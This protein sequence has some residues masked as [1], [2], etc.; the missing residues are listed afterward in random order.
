V[1]LS[2]KSGPATISGNTVTV[3]GIGTVMLAADQ[4]GTT[5]YL[6]AKEVTTTFTVGK[7]AQTIAPFGTLSPLTVGV[8]P[9]TIT[10][11]TASS[12]L[13]VAVT[14]KS[15]PAKLSGDLV[16]I[17]GAGTVVLSASQAG[18]TLFN[19]A[20][21]VTATFAV[22]KTAQTISAF[23]SISNQAYGA[24]AFAIT[25]PT[26]SSGLAVTVTVLS[27]PAKISRG[28]V[29]LSGA[30]TVVLAANQA[31]NTTIAAAPEVT[32]SFTVSQK[33][34]T[35]AAFATVPAKTYGVSAF[36]IAPPKATSGLAVTLS[37]QSGPATMISGRVM[38]TGVGTV[39]VAADQPGN[40]NF[41]AA[42]EVTTSFIVN[43]ANQTISAFRSIAK[44]TT[45]SAPFAITLPTSTSKLLV[46]VT[47]SGPATIS[48]DIV[49]ITG[50]G[51]VT[52]AA[53]QAGTA[54]YN[55]A[56]QVMI[57]FTVN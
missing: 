31:G 40:A 26:A 24:P 10:L 13:P 49:T 7:E 33:S 11:P 45:T 43:P 54:N 8:T 18:N 16:T 48:G 46:T 19:A 3:T 34:Q 53:N 37:I 50:A 1:T 30:G 20:T 29:A 52:L 42:P 15:G 39:V 21:P 35:I 27:G 23:A 5:G 55:A 41:S 2:V 38:I 44:K 6:P 4:A 56:P 51:V 9:F 36:A 12:S 47:V 25:L 57:S 28:T 17:T 14:V 32:T 22:N